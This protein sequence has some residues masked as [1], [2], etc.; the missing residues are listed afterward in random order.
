LVEDPWLIRETYL[1]SRK[2]ILNFISNKESTRFLISSARIPHSSVEYFDREFPIGRG[3]L[4]EVIKIDVHL[5]LKD[6]NS[7]VFLLRLIFLSPYYLILDC[8]E[9]LNL[10]IVRLIGF[11]YLANSI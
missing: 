6:V 5:K 3:E 8:M 11:D 1:T 2:Q 7:Y 4:E 9:S 10:L